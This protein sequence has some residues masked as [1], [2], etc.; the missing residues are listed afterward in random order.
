MSIASRIAGDMFKHPRQRKQWSRL[1]RNS[2]SV[3]GSRSIV[4]SSHLGNIFA[5][6]IF[7]I[8]PLVLYWICASK[9]VSRHIVNLKS[10]AKAARQGVSLRKVP[11]S[12]EVQL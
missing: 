1:K 11:L 8:V 6:E 4:C 9:L 10:L 7:R 3:I 12:Q 5:R 2:Q